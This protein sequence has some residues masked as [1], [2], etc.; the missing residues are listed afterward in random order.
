VDDRELSRGEIIV[1]TECT[2]IS[3]GTELANYM[4]KDP[5]VFKPGTWCAYPWK[6]GY[7]NVGVVRAKGS[8]VDM[9]N[10]GQRV[11]TMAP[12]ASIVRYDTERLA[13]A[14]PQGIDP[15][16]A[17]TSRMAGVALCALYVC[18]IEGDPWVVV[19]GLGA[20]GNIAAQS[21]A[22]RGCRVIGVDPLECRRTVAQSC[23]VPC[24][25]GGSAQEVQRAIGDLTQGQMA[26][27]SVDA[28]GHAAVVGQA[29]DA[30]ATHGQLVLLGTPREPIEGN[31]TAMWSQVHRKMA[32][33]RGAL[34][35]FLP[36][37]PGPSGRESQFSKQQLI[38]NW[39]LQGKLKLEPLISHRVSPAEIKQAY[40][41]LLEQP[42]VYTGVVLDWRA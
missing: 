28:V 23:G 40:E 4:A 27:V 37:Y 22:I 34:E 17:A 24:V 26:G 29:L 41:G 16:V 32:T 33:V 21:F 30:L 42:E 6:S 7:A 25:V 36:M 1:E 19:F 12:H 2:F 14:V 20:V 15:A 38:F 18:R 35:W 39:L 11:F 10:V 9:V 5:D 8:G 31:V 3:A 13:L